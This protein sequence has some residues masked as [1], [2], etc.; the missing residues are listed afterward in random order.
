MVSGLSKKTQRMIAIANKVH[1]NGI[2]FYSFL[3]RGFIGLFKKGVDQPLRYET[4]QN[5]PMSL[6]DW[7]FENGRSPIVSLEKEETLR[8]LR[9]QKKFKYVLGIVDEGDEFFSSS[10]AV[11][12]EWCN[13]NFDEILCLSI[14][15]DSPLYE[16]VKGQLR[17]NKSTIVIVRSDLSIG[18][19]FPHSTVTGNHHLNQ[20]KI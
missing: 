17:T 15:K 16:R 3:L 5:F 11:V 20:S 12:E 14:N 9:R 1:D 18:Y 19:H 4:D 2:K 7:A 8:Y 6:M 10:S 13:E